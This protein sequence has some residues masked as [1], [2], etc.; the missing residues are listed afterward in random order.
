M[1][2]AGD[3][4]SVGRL[5]Q[6]PPHPP[7]QSEQP[8]AGPADQGQ[9]QSPEPQAKRDGDAAFLWRK[10]KTMQLGLKVFGCMDVK[11]SDERWRYVAAQKIGYKRGYAHSFSN[12]DFLTDQDP[13]QGTDQLKEFKQRSMG[14]L[15]GDH[16][17]RS[18]LGPSSPP[19]P[20]S[21]EGP[22]TLSDLL[23]RRE[24]MVTDYSD[25]SSPTLT[26]VPLSAFLRPKFTT[27]INVP[28]PEGRTDPPKRAGS[29]RAPTKQPLAGRH[30][31]R[32]KLAA[33]VARGAPLASAQVVLG[34]WYGEEDILSQSSSVYRHEYTHNPKLQVDHS[35]ALTRNL[36]QLRSS[37]CFQAEW[38]EQLQTQESILQALR[39]ETRKRP[40]LDAS[41]APRASPNP[42]SSV[43]RARSARPWTSGARPLGSSQGEPDLPVRFD[44]PDSA[45]TVDSLRTP[46]HG[47][48]RP[49][50]QP[51]RQRHRQP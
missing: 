5:G 45:I 17:P 13:N 40:P 15:L 36:E 6:Q 34:D 9:A 44:R 23:M 33:Q 41:R 14:H 27:G 22:A 7:L 49:Q 3:V 28:G 30:H 24:S 16:P 46:K 8:R 51:S 31:N 32:A 21:P 50:P 35:L 38:L 11:Y 26:K 48:A 29:A 10:L 25:V 42:P 43:R 20:R 1:L 37:T 4:V 12:A 19:R 47:M 2:S 18:P 39:P